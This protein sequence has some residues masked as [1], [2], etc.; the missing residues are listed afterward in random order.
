MRPIDAD[1]VLRELRGLEAVAAAS[2]RRSG[3]YIRGVPGRRG[4]YVY[5]SGPNDARTTSRH[6]KRQP[7]VP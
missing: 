4:G 6:S 1:P 2:L 3:H 5:V 7:E